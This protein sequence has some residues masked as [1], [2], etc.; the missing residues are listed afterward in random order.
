MRGSTPP[1]IGMRSSFV[2]P[3]ARIDLSRQEAYKKLDVYPACGS[4]VLLP[5]LLALRLF[6]PAC[7]RPIVKGPEPFHLVYPACAGI[8]RPA[9][10]FKS[11][12][13]SLPRM[14][15][16]RPHREGASDCRP[17]FTPHARGSTYFGVHYVFEYFVYPACA[18]IDPR[19]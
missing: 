8:D 10:P 16:D 18:G 5:Y 13:T 12:R 11:S 7:D 6:T 14:R 4:T 19:T 1:L 3:H 17:P 15:G 9:C 2:T